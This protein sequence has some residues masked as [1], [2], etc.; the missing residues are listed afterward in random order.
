MR[1]RAI[2]PGYRIQTGALAAAPL[3]GPPLEALDPT[4]GV[5][6]L[7]TP[8]VERV[9][10]GADLHVELRLGRSSRELIAAGATHVSFYVLGVDSLLHLNLV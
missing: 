1:L 8:R 2:L 3:G 9:A 4:A 5:D 6:Q 10:L 7:L